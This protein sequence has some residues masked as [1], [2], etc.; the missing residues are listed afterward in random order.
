MHNA[1]ETLE[2]T[3]RIGCRVACT[4]CPQATLVK[5][6]KR[7]SGSSLLSM[8]VFRRCLEKTPQQVQIIFCGMCEPWSNPDCT[9]FVLFAHERGHKIALETTL[10]GMTLADIERL[11]AISLEYIT[12]H[13][14]SGEGFEHIEVDN[15]YLDVLRAI[16][17]GRPPAN[18][19]GYRYYGDSLHPK[20][21]QRIQEL[22]IIPNRLPL[23]TRARNIEIPGIH[24][25][26]KRRGNIG[27]LRNMR[28]NVLLPNGDVVL[29]SHDYNL[30]HILG[31]LLDDSYESLFTGEEY[32]KVLT[33]LCDEHAETLC[34]YCD[35]FAY[36][37]DIRG[38]VMDFIQEALRRVH[39][40]GDAWQASCHSRRTAKRGS[41]SVDA[42]PPHPAHLIKNISSHS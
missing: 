20:I 24:L 33:G 38:R 35:S 15:R 31:N 30:Q 1:Q 12:I 7:R 26:T 41:K 3:T 25:P 21:Q 40:R 6:Y 37:T 2:I 28:Y 11:D 39:A 34:R 29:C 10:V 42:T 27:C 5:Q 13:L 16:A 32:R 17:S 23:I 22:G 18:G 8:D 19:C 4:Y 14:P 36:Q 9:E